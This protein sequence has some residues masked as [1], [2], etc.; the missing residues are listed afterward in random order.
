M[1]AEGPLA[2]HKTARM[3]ISLEGFCCDTKERIRRL[4]W[5]RL[6][7]PTYSPDLVPSDIHLFP[8]FKS[9]LSG[10][11]FRRNEEVLQ[12]MKNFL[13]SLGADFYQGGFLKLISRYDKCINVGG[14][15]RKN[16]LFCYAIVCFR[17]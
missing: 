2:D 1:G 9:A 11:H 13:R 7:H 10:R 15:Y 5:E 4:G 6:D 17:L 3:A 12:S 8:T 16:F 14:E